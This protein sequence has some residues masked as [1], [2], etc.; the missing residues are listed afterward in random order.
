MLE[1]YQ[2]ESVLSQLCVFLLY[3]DLDSS[4]LNYIS[5]KHDEDS[6]V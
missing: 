2:S 4:A 6:L 1:Y 5:V 3:K